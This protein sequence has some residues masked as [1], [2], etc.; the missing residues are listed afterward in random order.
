MAEKPEELQ[1]V[2][3]KALATDGPVII[4]YKIDSDDMV[5]PMVAPGAPINEIISKEDIKL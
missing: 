5:F 1:E 2:L 4:D 3:E